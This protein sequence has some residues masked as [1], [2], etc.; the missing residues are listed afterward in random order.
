M[1]LCV[2]SRQHYW[3]NK[4][5]VCVCVFT[6]ENALMTESMAMQDVLEITE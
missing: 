1:W 2:D 4:I 3:H 5:A 6:S